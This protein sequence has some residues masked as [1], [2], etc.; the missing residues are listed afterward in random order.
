[1]NKHLTNCIQPS[2]G[3]GGEF[4]TSF[5]AASADACGIAEALPYTIP[6]VVVRGIVRQT[7]KRIEYTAREGRPLTVEE[8]GS[9]LLRKAGWSV[10][11]GDDAHFFFSIFSC[12]FKDSFFYE[13]CRNYVGPSFKKRITRL[14]EAA[15]QTITNNAL[16]P[17]LLQEAKDLILHYYSE[18]SPRASVLTDIAEHIP[19]FE[20]SLIIRLMKFYRK[21]GYK[22]KGAPDLFVVNGSAFRFI[23]MKSHTDS[24]SSAQYDFFENYLATVGNNILVLRVLPENS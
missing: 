1:M 21:A 10:Y 13:V 18:Y 5:V 16:D 2:P 17:Q 20:E 19:S 6:H 23:E 4:L 8:Y 24:L 14:D 3:V 15:L 12:N 11:K 9:Y 22:T 7:G